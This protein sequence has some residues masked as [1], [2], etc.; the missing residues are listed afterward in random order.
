M[1]DTIRLMAVVAF[2]A[3]AC[4]CTLRGTTESETDTT[5]NITVSTSGRTW[6][7]PDGLVRDDQK[8]NAFA[9]LNFENLRQDMARGEG[10]YLVSF[11][12]LLG[13]QPDRRAAFFAFAQDRYPI[14]GVST[15]A[16]EFIARLDRE[17]SRI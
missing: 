10:E 5:N 15:T 13:V 1:R 14:V 11:S 9:T 4:A 3:L 17:M 12:N 7:T 6:F 16:G 8:V 2:S